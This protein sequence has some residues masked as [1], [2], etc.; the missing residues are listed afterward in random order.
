MEWTGPNG[1]DVWKAREFI[2][3]KTR[4]KGRWCVTVGEEAHHNFLSSS[5]CTKEEDKEGDSHES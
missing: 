1:R 5:S 4:G 3:K 2:K